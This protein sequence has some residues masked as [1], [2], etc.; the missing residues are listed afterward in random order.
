MFAW[1][2]LLEIYE[3]IFEVL[4]YF[5]PYAALAGRGSRFRLLIQTECRMY[6]FTPALTGI[7]IIGVLLLFAFK[8]NRGIL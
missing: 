4:A 5:P 8:D 2:V 1:I 7:I 6:Q 3:P